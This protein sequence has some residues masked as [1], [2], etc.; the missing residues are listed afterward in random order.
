M[1]PTNPRLDGRVMLAPM[2][3]DTYYPKRLV[4]RG[5][6]LLWALV[7][8]IETQK[9]IGDAVLL[10]TQ[11]TTELFNQ[12][13]EDFHEQD[14]EIETVAR[15]AIA[16]DIRAILEAYGYDVDIEEAISGRDW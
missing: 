7:E 15:E 8:R 3:G 9:P 16:D 5:Q 14:S 10:L 1:A 6:A 11:A 4:A 13:D 12:L 2:T